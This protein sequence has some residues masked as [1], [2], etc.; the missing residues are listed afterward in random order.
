LNV[1]NNTKGAFVVDALPDLP[2]G[3]HRLRLTTTLGLQSDLTDPITIEAKV[4]PAKPA[5]PKE[6]YWYLGVESITS[7]TFCRTF[8]EPA[9]KYSND[10]PDPAKWGA[11]QRVRA[12]FVTPADYLFTKLTKSEYDAPDLC[13]SRHWDFELVDDDDVSQIG[14]V[15][16]ITKERATYH[17]ETLYKLDKTGHIV[18]LEKRLK[19][20]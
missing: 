9:E 10:D 7:L 4:E 14:A 17:L 8:Q 1:N 12:K 16:A 5:N 19:D 3:S 18:K 6:V 20:L 15:T 13:V 11:L 2:V